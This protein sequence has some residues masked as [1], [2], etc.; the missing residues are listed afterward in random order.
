[1]L[2]LSSTTILGIEEAGIQCVFG[3]NEKIFQV[4]V[5]QRLKIIFRSN[6]L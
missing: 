2:L 5:N 6:Y 4:C 1:M 3:N